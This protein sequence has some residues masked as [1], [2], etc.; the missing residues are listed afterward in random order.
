MKEELETVTG[1]Y[2]MA[3]EYLV[4][5]S[6][7]LLAALIILLVGWFIAAKVANAVQDRKSVV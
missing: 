1:L 7:Q 2:Q 4:T 5:Y 6:F 3:I